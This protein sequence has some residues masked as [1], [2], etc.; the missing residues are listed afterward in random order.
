MSKLKLTSDWIASVSKATAMNHYQVASYANIL[1]NQALSQ[2][3][4]ERD[5][6]ALARKNGKDLMLI[7]RDRN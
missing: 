3:E 7:A 1:W 4:I 2:K 5:F 6:I